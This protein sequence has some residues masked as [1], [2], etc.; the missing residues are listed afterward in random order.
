MKAL[1]KSLLYS[2]NKLKTIANKAF[3]KGSLVVLCLVFSVVVQAQIN[4]VQNPSFEYLK[5]CLPEHN[6]NSPFNAPPWDSIRAGGGG[7]DNEQMYY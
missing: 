6:T 7:R 5:D 1:L 3:L 4:M 2:N